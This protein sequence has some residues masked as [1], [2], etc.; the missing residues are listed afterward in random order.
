MLQVSVDRIGRR[1]WVRVRRRSTEVSELKSIV[2]K[3][4]VT[5]QS[6]DIEIDRLQM[7]LRLLRQKMY[8]PKSE[9]MAIVDPDV[10]THL[11][12]E[13]EAT[14]DKKEEPEEEIEVEAYRKKKGGRRPLPEN[15]PRIE[16]VH[17]IPEEEKVCGCNL[18]KLTLP[19]LYSYRISLRTVK[20]KSV[21][22]NSPSPL[23]NILLG[24][25][26]N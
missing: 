16:E 2:Q 20:L 12:N 13:D 25:N 23:T 6:K 18:T 9:R 21:I 24:K 5:I 11:F 7:E 1:Y 17:D 3:N 15:L 19:V 22:D 26:M 8:G 4:V 14:A 10:Q